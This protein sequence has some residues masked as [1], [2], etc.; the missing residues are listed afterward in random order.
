[1]RA[2]RAKLLLYANP[3]LN[4]SKLRLID[5]KLTYFFYK[6][7]LETKS[8]RCSPAKISTSTE[9][10]T[11]LAVCILFNAFFLVSFSSLNTAMCRNAFYIF[12]IQLSVLSYEILW[13][14]LGHFVV[15]YVVSRCVN[16]SVCKDTGKTC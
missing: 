9:G 11:E 12:F 5:L 10:H 6:M 14:F 3:H 8:L 7:F 2:F 16:A 1:M 4:I 15:E 13:G